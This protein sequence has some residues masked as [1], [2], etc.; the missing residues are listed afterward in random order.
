MTV[1]HLVRGSNPRAGATITFQ[2]NPN[3]FKTLHKQRPD[4]KY[5]CFKSFHCIS[6]YTFTFHNTQI[7]SAKGKAK[8][9]SHHAKNFSFLL[10][11][12]NRWKLDPAYDLTFS[13]GPGEEHSTTYLGEGRVPTQEH[14][15]KL[16]I[17]EV[18]A[19]VK[20]FSLYAKS[21][22]V[23]QN[24]IKLIKNVLSMPLES[25]LKHKKE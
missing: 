18:E 10:D 3:H 2:T 12:N 24:S 19:A 25:L 6:Y 15:E 14:L 16:V 4:W 9:Y 23:S 8:P 11:E 21:I 1:N 22:G 13:Y 20:K 7:K 17:D 5:F